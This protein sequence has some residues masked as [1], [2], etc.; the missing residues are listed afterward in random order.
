MNIGKELINNAIWCW[1][2]NVNTITDEN[3][4]AIGV[5]VNKNESTALIADQ[6]QQQSEQNKELAEELDGLI[7]KFRY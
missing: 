5:I 6:I 7:G 1:I 2:N 4:S 3:R